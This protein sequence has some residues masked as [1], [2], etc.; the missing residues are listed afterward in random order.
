M[1]FIIAFL[2]A[3]AGGALIG[4]L[5]TRGVIRYQSSGV[6]RVDHSDPDSPYLFLELERSDVDEIMKNRYVTLRVNT[7]NYISQK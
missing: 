2:V 3:F 1:V 6:L 5:I 7:K 4:M